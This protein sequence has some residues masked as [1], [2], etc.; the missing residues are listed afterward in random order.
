MIHFVVKTLFK[1]QGPSSTLV[2]MP[3]PRA[4]SKN[5]GSS[6]FCLKAQAELMDEGGCQ[7]GKF[8]GYDSDYKIV[9]RTGNACRRHLRA[10]GNST[11][12]CSPPTLTFIPNNGQLKCNGQIFF[13]SEENVKR[14]V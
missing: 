9:D 6:H 12:T 2:N 13:M 5:N 7:I 4:N 8:V 3:P 11:K 14:V 10:S 1:I